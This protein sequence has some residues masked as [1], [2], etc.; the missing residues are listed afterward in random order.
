M[1]RAH[2]VY[3]RWQ[4][5]AYLF[6]AATT[7]TL[8]ELLEDPLEDTIPSISVNSWA[9]NL[10]SC[11]RL[12]KAIQNTHNIEWEYSFQATIKLWR[13]KEELTQSVPHGITE[14]DNQSMQSNKKGAQER[15]DIRWL[16]QQLPG[17]P[18]RAHCIHFIN[19]DDSGS[20][21][22]CFWSCIGKSF[23]QYSLTLSCV[24]SMYWS[25]AVTSYQVQKKSLKSQEKRNHSYPSTGN[26]HPNK[27]NIGS[28]GK[29]L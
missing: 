24:C 25:S 12:W 16:S 14:R 5:C 2:G 21:C 23:T 3:S 7:T 22:C 11:C 18:R 28:N 9:T 15:A 1:K 29:T 20:A 4:I 8:E 13:Y 19:E 26:H 27:Q 17:V 10:V 6:V